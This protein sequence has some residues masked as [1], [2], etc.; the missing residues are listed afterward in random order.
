M[1]INILQFLASL[2]IVTIFAFLWHARTGRFAQIG[3]SWGYILTGFACLSF[4]EIFG[5]VLSLLVKQGRV[6]AAATEPS[7][8]LGYIAIVLGLLFVAIGVYRWLSAVQELYIDSAIAKKRNI[9]LQERLSRNGV[10]LSKVPAALYRTSGSLSSGTSEIVFVNDKI[11]ELLGYSRAN[12]EANPMLFASLM[13]DEDKKKLEIERKELWHQDSFVIEH[14]FRHKNGEYRWLRRHLHR[15]GGDDAGLVEWDGCVYDIT[16]LKQA[17]ARLTNFLEAAPDPVI[18]ANSKGEI[19]LVN[20]QAERLFGYSKRE[21]L[22]Q[23]IDILV[24]EGLHDRPVEKFS[25]YLNET[26]SRMIDVGVDLRG[27]C[28]V[29]TEFPVE[30]S[31]SPIECGD[32]KLLAFAIRDVSERKNTEAQLRQSQKMEAVGQ[33]TGGIAH[34]FNNMLTVVIGNLQLLE[35][36]SKNDEAINRPTQ[37]AMDASLRAAELTKRLLA[38]S[39]QQ[40]LTP[41]NMKINDLVAGIEPLL[42]RTITEHVSL[43]IKLADDLWLARIDP[44][45]LE[46]ALINLAINARDAMHATSHGRLTIETMNTVLG[47]TYAAQQTDVTPG[48]YVMVAVSDNGEGIPEDVLPDVFDP[49]YSTKEIGKG[50]G[51]GLSMVYGF[52][53]QSKGHIKLYSEEGHG[54]T[55]KIYIP[56]SKATHED[57]I[58][59]TVRTEAVPGGDETILLVEDDEAVRDVAIRLLTSLGYRVLH[60]E[61]GSEALTLLDEHEDIDLLF[62]DIVMPGGMTGVELGQ[63]ATAKNQSLKVLYTSGYTDTTVFNNGL[64]ERSEDVLNKPYRKESLAQSV[65]DVL[66]KE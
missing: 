12:F 8:V 52:V 14:R 17:E 31:L 38:F 66:D 15:L 40:L 57:S 5:L 13:H 36:V 39:K 50:S 61:C 65:R 16:D 28:K 55:V 1:F 45:Q 63:R 25:A 29:G 9:D 2:I 18:T 49:F 24:P 48:E 56:R 3:K 41:R 58:E 6:S 42:H 62:T 53:K 34:D 30:I 60:A 59:Q 54:T 4:G 51:L 33:L 10:L 27:R 20:A 11:E 32:E 26:T 43:K 22:G 37:A 19:V 47:D 46:N 21:L 35:Q 64:L 44:S 23:Y 7:I